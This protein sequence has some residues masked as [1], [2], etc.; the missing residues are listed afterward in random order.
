MNPDAIETLRQHLITA[1]NAL[2]EETRRLFHG[3]GRCWAGLEHVTVDWLQGV[4]LVSL[5][6]DPGQAERQALT[7]RLGARGQS[8]QWRSGARLLL[9]G[10]CLPDG[11]TA[12][13][14]GGVPEEWLIRENGLRYKLDLGRKQN[15][16]LF[17][18]MRYGRR[19]VQEQTRGK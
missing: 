2:P 4:L 17:L 7:A 13:L 15:N 19:W 10:R 12:A 5:F 16:G 8:A 1:L 9:Q 3:R 14:L 18:D 6:R 11:A